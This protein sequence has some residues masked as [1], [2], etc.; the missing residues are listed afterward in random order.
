MCQARHT[1]QQGRRRRGVEE[2]NSTEDQRIDERRDSARQGGEHWRDDCL[3]NMIERLR[4]TKANNF[5]RTGL[6]K[7]ITS[8]SLTLC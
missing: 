4:L 1:V 5:L 3:N 7:K 2:R 8:S 6:K